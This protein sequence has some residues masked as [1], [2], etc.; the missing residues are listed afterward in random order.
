MST[1]L[2]TACI[3]LHP[4]DNV[5]VARADLAAGTPVEA[6]TARG[7]VFSPQLSWAET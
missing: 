3:R 5:V 6:V 7:A 4:A 1:A 2:S